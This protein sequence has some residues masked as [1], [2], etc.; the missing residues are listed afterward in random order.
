M[1]HGCPGMVPMVSHARIQTHLCHGDLHKWNITWVPNNL[2]YPAHTD[3]VII[4][5]KKFVCR[6]Y[7]IIHNTKKKKNI[8]IFAKLF[9]LLD[10]QMG[11]FVYTGNA[12]FLQSITEQRK[13]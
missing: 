10:D 2:H 8:I 1:E 7:D 9:L 5:S 13:K 11:H 4:F 12:S 3:L 6:D